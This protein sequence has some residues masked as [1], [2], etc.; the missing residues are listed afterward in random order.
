MFGFLNPIKNIANQYCRCVKYAFDELGITGVF[1]L[2]DLNIDRIFDCLIKMDGCA[3]TQDQKEV[4]KLA[5]QEMIRI[6]KENSLTTSSARDVAWIL[7]MTNLN[8]NHWQL[9]FLENINVINSVLKK[10][11]WY[12][13]K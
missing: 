4:I 13:E 9:V 8:H 1:P 12:L 6:K 2:D 10:H 7:I 11:F 3:L 5:K